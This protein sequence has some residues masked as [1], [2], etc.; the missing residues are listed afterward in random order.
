[1]ASQA[2][3]ESPALP[4]HD[5]STLNVTEGPT[6]R[7]RTDSAAVDIGSLQTFDNPIVAASLDSMT[8]GRR[9]QTLRNLHQNAKE[10]P[11]QSDEGKFKVGDIAFERTGASPDGTKIR[12]SY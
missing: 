9:G 10:K 6:H 7:S 12:L 8:E 2:S 3:L 4:K 11:R 5:I 1:M